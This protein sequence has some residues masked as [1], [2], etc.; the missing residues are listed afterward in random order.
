MGIAAGS[1]IVVVLF[2]L[3]PHSVRHSKR[4]QT[5][6]LHVL[7]FVLGMLLMFGINLATHEAHVHE[8]DANNKVEQGEILG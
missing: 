5:Y 7:W 8:E 4:S 1:F 2:D 3:I 6:N